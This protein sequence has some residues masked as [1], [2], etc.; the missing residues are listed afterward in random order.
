MS[1]ASASPR[2]RAR[3][4]PA[5]LAAAAVLSIAL[6]LGLEQAT[7][8][9][10][11][12]QFAEMLTAAR[13]MQAAGRVLWM[14]KEARGLTPTAQADPNRTGMIGPEFTPITTTIGELAAKRTATNPDFAAA[15][16]RQIAP[17]G[18]ARGTPVVLVVSGSFV[19]GDVAAIAAV[20]ALGLR[21]IVIASLSASMWGANEP[22]FNLLDMLAALR[23]RDVIR[24]RALAAVLGGSGAVG[25]SMD[26]DGVA[27]LRRSAARDGV[28]I[29]EV[30]PLAALIDVLLGHVKAAI[31]GPARP[32]AVINVGGALI[33]LGS[34]RESY[35]LPPGLTRQP[36]SCSDGTP[37]LAIRLAADGVPILHVINIRRLALEW[38]L[39]FDPAPLPIPGNNRAIYGSA[40]RNPVQ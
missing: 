20:E 2:V 18:P 14:E 3:L 9:P 37:G 23:E 1:A 10:I 39:P 27:A 12:P 35:E 16:V 40:G 30:R 5:W 17:L 6:W 28:P 33:G 21:P 26:P 8:R 25:G 19:G 24:A 11:H 31:G 36:P 4:R 7:R 13:A 38:G 32:G 34:C 22:E 29:V 15:L